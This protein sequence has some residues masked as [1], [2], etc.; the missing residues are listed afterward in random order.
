MNQLFFSSGWRPGRTG[1]VPSVTSSGPA[2]GLHKAANNLS[3]LF[4]HLVALG[5][6]S[7][8]IRIQTAAV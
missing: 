4:H 5:S 7:L 1:L 2:S 8:E 3:S 6:T